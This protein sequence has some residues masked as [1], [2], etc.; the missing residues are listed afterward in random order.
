MWRVKQRTLLF[1][2][3]AVW[4]IAGVNVARIGFFA[5]R[6]IERVWY[7]YALSV[8][9][10]LVFERMFLGMTHRHTARIVAYREKQPFWR[11]FDR[12]G[13][14]VMGCMMSVGIGIRAFGIL[15]DAF[16]AWFY[17]GLGSALGSAGLVFLK[18]DLLYE[19]WRVAVTT[20]GMKPTHP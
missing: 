9:V 2:A 8:A 19:R 15:P 20:V 16:I 14:V 6:T 5:Y 12:K 4:L 7:E 13:L 10:F 18:N 1:I 17:T 3:G 11:F